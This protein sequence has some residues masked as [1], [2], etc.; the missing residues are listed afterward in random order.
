MVTY[1]PIV[2]YDVATSQ[3]GIAFTDGTQVITDDGDGNLV[4][5]VDGAGVNRID[6]DTGA[7]DMSFNIAPPLA[8]SIQSTYRQ[9]LRTPSEDIPISKDQLA[10]KNRYDITTTSE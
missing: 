4:G 9:L 1:P 7:Y 5:D 8:A 2:E 6:Y 10:V 3:K